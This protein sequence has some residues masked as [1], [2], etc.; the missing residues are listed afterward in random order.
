MLFQSALTFAQVT[1]LG[2]SEKVAN[3]LS[4]RYREVSDLCTEDDLSL[5]PPRIQMSLAG[6]G[7]DQ[8]SRVEEFMKIVHEEVGVAVNASRAGTGSGTR[9]RILEVRLVDFREPNRTLNVATSLVG[10]AAIDPGRYRVELVLSKSDAKSEIAHAYIDSTP[11][12]RG[13]L[14]GNAFSRQSSIRRN[15]RGQLK[16]LKV[17]WEQRQRQ[18]IAREPK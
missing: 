5:L 18:C 3:G 12:V 16:K 11:T 2:K 15:I 8:Q 14:L 7:S 4:I 1:D 13:L 17:Y 10:G 6:M 9:K